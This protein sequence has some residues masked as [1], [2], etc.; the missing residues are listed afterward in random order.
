MNHKRNRLLM[1]SICIACASF[2]C[3]S[4]STHAASP[5]P[6]GGVESKARPNVLMACEGRV[7]G[8]SP[9][10]EVGAAAD[11]VI[12]RVFVV[13]NQAVKKGDPLAE[14]D[15]GDRM[16]ALRTARAQVESA[17]EARTRLGRGSREEERQIAAEKTA[18]AK[19]ILE[20]ATV[21]LAR[22]KA[23]AERGEIPRAMLDDAVRDHD[24]SAA[25]VKEAVRQEQLV[26]AGALPEELAKA[27]A[28]VAAAQSRVHEAEER[29]R[30]C[31]VAAPMAGAVLQVMARPGESFSTVMPRPL[32]TM[33]DLSCRRVRAEVDERD[34]PKLRVGQK[35]LVYC[36]SRP[37]VKYPGVV[38]RISSIMG[39]KKVL[40]L[41]PAEK[42]DRD[43]LESMIDLG[44]GGEFVPVG[45]RVIVQFLQ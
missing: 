18:A 8:A 29:V 43:V 20:R 21:N 31:T 11:G 15:C 35:T 33:A 3:S 6:R 9:T 17:Q 28:E 16:A 30:K 36:E 40:S 23:L 34:V 2:G 27:D 19:S 10:V 45:M 1:A 26:N 41:D 12:Q 13:E 24:V 25:E 22:M 42:N 7:E 38:S 44:R 14:I 39:R 37:D 32:F 4:G 5:D